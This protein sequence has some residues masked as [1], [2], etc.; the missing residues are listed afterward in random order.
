MTDS[1]RSRISQAIEELSA[2]RDEGEDVVDNLEFVA[3]FHSVSIGKLRELAEERWGGPLETDRARNAAH[4]EA[5]ARRLAEQASA[6]AH[7]RETIQ[8]AKEAA[9]EVWEKCCPDGEPDWD[10]CAKR[11]L[12]LNKVKEA[13]LRLE[14]SDLFQKIGRDFR[15]ASALYRKWHGR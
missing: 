7:H 11:F 13:S 14:I 1:G 9:I 12:S 6:L 3:S 4:F 10:Y 8:R 5:A 15:S 2:Y